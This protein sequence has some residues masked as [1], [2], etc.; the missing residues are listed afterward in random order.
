MVL[1]WEHVRACLGRVRQEWECW[2]ASG[3]CGVEG[4]AEV[5][6]WRRARALRGAALLLLL[7]PANV[8]AVGIQ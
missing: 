3:T 5:L 2:V 7:F 1:H 6:H 4:N 8:A